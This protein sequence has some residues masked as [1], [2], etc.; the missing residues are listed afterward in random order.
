MGGG[1]LVE[2]RQGP[3]AEEISAESSLV[4]MVPILAGARVAWE[5]II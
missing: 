4:T 3:E 1:G 2:T 5:F